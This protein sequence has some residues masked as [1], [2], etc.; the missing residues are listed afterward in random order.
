[1]KPG[2]TLPVD[3]KTGLP[4]DGT[5]QTEIKI[6]AE[7]GEKAKVYRDRDGKLVGADGKVLNGVPVTVTGEGLDKTEHV[8]N[9]TVTS[10]ELS[11]NKDQITAQ[12]RKAIGG[13]E[14]A[15]NYQT[16]DGH[17]VFRDPL[18]GELVA[19]A[20]GA[21]FGAGAKIVLVNRRSWSRPAPTKRC[22]TATK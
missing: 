12:V 9:G 14:R 6:T 5:L 7:T 22:L 13:Y 2:T 17:D 20:K 1:M 21:K 10:G 3:P 16:A 4:A 11:I 8:L 19:D 15:P 18:T